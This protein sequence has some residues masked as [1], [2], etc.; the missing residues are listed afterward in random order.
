M[1]TSIFEGDS[2]R[3][4]FIKILPALEHLCLH[5]AQDTPTWM[6]TD[7][8]QLRYLFVKNATEF[9]SA[10]FRGM[11]R[12]PLPLRRL[13]IE[14]ILYDGI[15]HVPWPIFS[16]L[17]RS[18]SGLEELQIETTNIL[19]PGPSPFNLSGFLEVM[20]E[21]LLELHIPLQEELILGWFVL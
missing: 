9:S 17:I 20:G 4:A 1:K 6:V 3:K 15:K 13:L 11:D 16:F 21:D 7:C 10:D 8:E 14:N 12:P 2:I 19:H 5:C 18:A